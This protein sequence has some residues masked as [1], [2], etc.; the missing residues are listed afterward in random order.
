MASPHVAGVAALWAERELKN[1]GTVNIVSLEA[2]LRAHARATGSHRQPT[3]T[4]VKG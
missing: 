4:W 2:Q 1:K 3:W